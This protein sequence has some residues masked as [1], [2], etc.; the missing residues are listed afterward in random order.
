VDHANV[1][2]ESQLQLLARSLT[3]SRS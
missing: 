2:A 1:R 3:P